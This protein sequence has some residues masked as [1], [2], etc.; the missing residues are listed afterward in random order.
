MKVNLLKPIE[1]DGQTYDSIN[2]DLEGLTGQ[3]MLL[4]ERL[5]LSQNATNQASL[6]KELSKEYQA[7]VAVQAAKLPFEFIQKVSAKDFSRITTAV[8]N[9]FI[10]AS[11]EE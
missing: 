2:L 11:A 3:D 10:A 9:F 5:F 6:L 8:G 1:F 7:F 4:V